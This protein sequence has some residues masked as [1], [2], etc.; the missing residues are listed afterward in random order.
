M[1]NFS[2]SSAAIACINL[3]KFGFSFTYKNEVEVNNGDSGKDE[4]FGLKKNIKYL[5]EKTD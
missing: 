5:N 2:K 1:R 4:D 3:I